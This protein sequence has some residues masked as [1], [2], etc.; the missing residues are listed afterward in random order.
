MKGGGGGLGGFLLGEGDLFN[1]AGVKHVLP[2][3]T[4]KN[5]RRVHRQ[6]KGTEGE[7]FL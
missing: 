5:K 1:F 4:F 6:L 2:E 3:G 7:R